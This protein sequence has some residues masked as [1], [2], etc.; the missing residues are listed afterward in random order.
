MLVGVPVRERV[1][2][3]DDTD[4]GGCSSSGPSKSL[5]AQPM[6]EAVA[7]PTALAEADDDPDADDDAD[8]D[9]DGEALRVSGTGA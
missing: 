1:A 7:E 2:G 4:A 5:P 8:A 9:A 6:Y 3:A